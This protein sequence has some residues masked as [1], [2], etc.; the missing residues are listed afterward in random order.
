MHMLKGAQAWYLCQIAWSSSAPL[1][2]KPSSTVAVSAWPVRCAWLGPYWLRA[3]RLVFPAYDLEVL[4]TSWSCVS[5]WLGALL[6]QAGSA[7]SPLLMRRYKVEMYMK[8][9]FAISACSLGVPFLYHLQRVPDKN[10]A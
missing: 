3:A 5:A 10:G 9:V 2:N 7:L 4:F 1:C 6:L 8:Y